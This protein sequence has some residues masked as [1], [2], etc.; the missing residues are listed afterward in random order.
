MEVILE[1]PLGPEP[2]PDVQVWHYTSNGQFIVKSAYR[3]G[4]QFMANYNVVLPTSS[5]FLAASG[6]C[7]GK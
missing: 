2:S 5:I 7:C 1:I 4:T 3:L 6:K